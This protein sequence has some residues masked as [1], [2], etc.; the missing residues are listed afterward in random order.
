MF[1]SP[2]YDTSPQDAD[3]SPERP[4][5]ICATPRCGSNLLC[6]GL[7]GTGCVG[8]AF[9]YFNPRIRGALERRWGCDGSLAAYA[10]ALYGRRATE[11]GQLGVKLH[12]DQA[13]ALRAEVLGAPAA[14][15][16]FGV[17]ADFLARLLPGARYVRIL[18][19]DVNRQAVSYWLAYVT[20]VWTELGDGGD[21]GDVA[22]RAAYSFEGIECCR[23]LIE[24]FELH[25]DRFLR[26]N[27]IEPVTVVYEKL[28]EDFEGTV[29][30]V[31]R[32]L[33]P[34]ASTPAVPPPVV[35]R[36]SGEVT[37]EMLER[38]ARDRERWPLPDPVELLP[39]RPRSVTGRYR[40][41]K[42]PAA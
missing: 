20:G 34:E 24:N 16:E 27:G 30:E 38:F 21:G 7:T 4:Y 12:W 14:E 29:R 40:A 3:S 10:R 42:P 9:E 2:E 13:V 36:Q 17:S 26:A 35:R 11:S 8:A 6:D 31:V 18:R 25:W 22:E 39:D 32:Y 1:L 28:V 33:A 23:R 15:P 5:V 41:A 19:Q 37:E